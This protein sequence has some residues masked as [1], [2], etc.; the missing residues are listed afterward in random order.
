M[1]IRDRSVTCSGDCCENDKAKISVI[2][3]NE[4]KQE[5]VLSCQ[6]QNSNQVLNKDC[7]TV[8]EKLKESN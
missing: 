6:C 3:D 5:L 8:S 4:N 7:V 2:P 1:C